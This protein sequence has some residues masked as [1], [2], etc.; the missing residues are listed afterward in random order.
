MLE[1]KQAETAN[2]ADVLMVLQSFI[3][4]EPVFCM[5]HLFSINLLH[6]MTKYINSDYIRDFFIALFD[7]NDYSLNI[8][9]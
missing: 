2:I 6:F 5:K 4:I 1:E 9:K 3:R 8:N 7:P